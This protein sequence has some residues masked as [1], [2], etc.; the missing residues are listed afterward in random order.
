[1][2]N[3]VKQANFKK[4]LRITKNSGKNKKANSLNL[5]AKPTITANTGIARI[6]NILTKKMRMRSLRVMRRLILNK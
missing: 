5:M 3:S 4:T 2:K 1:L 6:K